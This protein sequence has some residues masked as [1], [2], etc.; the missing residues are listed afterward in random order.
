[1]IKM[2]L[3]REPLFKPKGVYFLNGMTQ[4]CGTIGNPIGYRVRFIYRSHIMHGYFRKE[5]VNEVIT[6]WW[7]GHYGFITPFKDN[8]RGV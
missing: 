3:Y 1:M 5:P 8:D 2:H 6:L 4:S 7:I